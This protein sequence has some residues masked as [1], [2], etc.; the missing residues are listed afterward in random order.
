MSLRR[1]HVFAIIVIILVTKH[2]ICAFCQ[3]AKS[4]EE[5]ERIGSTLLASLT[6]ENVNHPMDY[7]VLK[8]CKSF[9][10][11][12]TKPN[13]IYEIRRKYNLKSHTVTLPANCVLSFN[14]GSIVNGK[15]VGDNVPFCSE[16]IDDGCFKCDTVGVFKRVGLVVK[17]SDIKMKPNSHD[18]AKD[19]Y[20][21]FK[22]AIEQG[23]NIYFDGHYYLHFQNPIIL[24]REL[25]LYGGELVYQ[26]NAFRLADGGGLSVNGSSITVSDKTPSSFF[27][28]SAKLLGPISISELSFIN[29]AI[30]CPYLAHAVFEDINSDEMPF[31]FK[32]VIVDH[33]VFSATGR[34]RILD[35]VISEK[36]SFTNNYYRNFTTTPIYIA[37]QHSVQASPND[38]SA[39]RYVAQNMTKGC[40]V[41]IDSN[42]FIGTPVSLD[43]YYCSALVKANQCAFTNNFVR[44]IINYSDGVDHSKATAYDAYL[45]CATVQYENNFVKDVISYSL[46]GGT[47]PKCQIGKSKTNPLFFVGGK[48]QRFYRNNCFVVS[49]DRFLKAGADSS[50]LYADIFGNNSY[51]DDYVWD[52]NSVIFKNAGLKTGVAAHG[53]GSFSLRNNYFELEDTKGSGLVTIRSDEKTDSVVICNNTFKLASQQL[54]PVF[55]Q[56]YYKEYDKSAQGRISI[57][58]NR[59]VNSAAKVFFFTG[60]EVEVKRNKEDNALI[61]GNLYLSKYSGSGTVV[62]VDHMDAELRFSG[63]GSEKGGLMQYFSSSSNGCFSI[64]V[65][66]VPSHGVN[67]YYAISND[68]CFIVE[69]EVQTSERI[70]VISI[71]V[72]VEKGIV[73]YVF[74]EKI[75]R[76]VPG[77]KVE[78][79][80]V[81]GESFQFRAVFYQSEKRQILFQL[82]RRGNHLNND[83]SL[84]F[85]FRS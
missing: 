76:L 11:Q 33:C 35:A 56:K 34:I 64:T 10:S 6:A 41:V 62:D 80:L 50:S 40:Q 4:I 31:G 81:E 1:I 13:T 53:Y 47:K 42:I 15:I 60:R 77:K 79:V 55:N 82:K 29:S 59:F 69:A 26:G 63:K 23:K 32:R 16:Q 46:N 44:D 70:E 14:G 27:C 65:D 22:S 39:Y 2:N 3:P 19:N 66:E 28:G 36:C 83:E 21:V 45:S 24:D 38:K 20:A 75:F 48:S 30:N 57:T 12:V 49:G 52:N 74:G 18:F 5:A 84:K 54:F 9:W 78:R 25:R 7:V 72:S 51:I 37:C 43:F 85:T 71:P 61:T 8:R 17:A 73:S 68:D 58:D 67:Y